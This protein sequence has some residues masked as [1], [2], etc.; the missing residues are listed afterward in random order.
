MGHTTISDVDTEYRLLQERLDRNVTG[1]PDSA[2]MRRV[3][4]LL[5]T[6]EQAHIAR[7]LPQVIAVSALAA[8]LEMDEDELNAHITAMAERGLALDFERNGKRYVMATPVVIGFYEFTFM[9]ERPDDP[10]DDYAEAFDAL[11]DDEAFVRSVF[12]GS[13]QLG[14]SFV[15]EE[16][17]TSEILDWERATEV[18]RTAESV[19]VSLCPCRTDARL[20]GEG[21]DGPTRTCLTFG[22]AADKLV[23][24]GIAEPISNDEAIEI[25]S[26]AKAAGLAQTGDNVRN[27]V[28]YMCNCCG[29]CCGM[30][31]SI[32]K[33]DIYDGIVPS[34]FVAVIDHEKCRGCTKCAKA[35]PVDAIEIVP[36]NG[37]GLRKNWAIVDADRC[38]GCGVCDDQCRW[39]AREMVERDEPRYIPE[40]TLERAAYM[41]IERGKLGDLLLDNVGSKLAP[42][43]AATV[44]VIEKMP[45]WKMA[46]ANQQLK[47]RFIGALLGRVRKQMASG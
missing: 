2:A 35:C 5:F 1:A 17:V 21:C 24:A 16:S 3:L 11:F 34:N 41:A 31:R 42:I 39:E 27:R 33:Y 20:R 14:R 23:R 9:R 29:C 38:L 15:R 4:R 25:L 36:T 8:K 45:P 22:G 44:R 26:T 32:K 7:Q 19:A 37:A 47:S 18:V 28:S 6:P 40:D 43:A 10:M 46:M 12:T 30:M 13:T